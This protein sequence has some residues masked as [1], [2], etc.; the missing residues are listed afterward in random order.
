MNPVVVGTALTDKE[1]QGRGLDAL[2]RALRQIVDPAMAAAADGRPWVELYQAKESQRLGRRFEADLDDPRLLLRILRFERGVFTQIEAVQRAWIDEIIQAANRAA[3]ATQLSAAQADRA[4]ET[5]S[6]L[7]ESLGL[8]DV[9]DEITAL[10][11][12]GARAAE[13]EP[14]AVPS[15]P[16]APSAPSAP[17]IPAVAHRV[18]A[19]EPVP[20]GLRRLSARIGELDIEVYVREA[21]NFALVHNGVSPVAAVVV[22]NHGDA[23]HGGVAVTIDVDPPG[24][25]SAAPLG[26]TLRLPVEAIPPKTTIDAV[27]HL[28]AWRL[29]PG[30]FIGLEE[31]VT[32]SV[33]L[34]VHPDPESDRSF[35]DSDTIRLLPADEWWAVSI[36]EALAAFV[37]PN[38][39]AVA[40]LLTE[41]SAMLE[42][43]TGSPS[44]EGYQSGPDRVHAIAE[45]LYDALRARGITYVEPPA[46]FEG[47]GQRIRSHSEVLT[48]RRAT[49]L[50]L[51]CLAAAALEQAGLN[52]VLVLV[53]GHAFTGYLTEEME[54]PAVAVADPPAMITLADS[55]MFDAFETTAATAGGEPVPFDTARAMVRRWWREG[56]PRVR[57]LLDVRAAHRRVLP[58]PSVRWDGDVRVVEVA[59]APAALHLRRAPDQTRRATTGPSA[60]PR[61]E[62]WKRSLLDLTYNNPHLKLK[63]ASS[64]AVHVPA[65]GL[66]TLED[67]LEDE[68]QITLLP[69]DELA[70][71]HLAQ[72]ARTAADVAAESMLAILGAER[73]AHVAVP[74]SGYSARMRGLYRRARTSAEETGTSS[75]YLT[76]GTLEWR[77]GSTREGRAPL[78]LLPVRLVG[79]RGSAPFQL[80]RDDTRSLEPNL[81][82][83]EKLRTTWGIDIPALVDPLTDDAGIDVARNLQEVRTGLIRAKR[84]EFHVEETA[85]LAVLQFS[86]IDMWR[87]VRDHWEH[88]LERPVVRHLVETPGVPFDDGVEP[89]GTPVDAE[90]TTHLPIPADGSQIE[91]VRW[92]AA[93][94]TFILEGPPGTGKS[95]TITNL[96]AHCLAEGKSVLFVAEK[97]AALDVVR[98]RLDAVGLGLLSLDLH[99]KSQT[100]NAVREQISAALEFGGASSSTWE[101]LRARYQSL[102]TSLARY[103]GLL[104]QPG[105]ADMSAWDARQVLLDLEGEAGTHAGAR[106]DVPRT[107]V[108]GGVDLAHV[109]EAAGRLAEALGTLGAAPDSSPWS[110]AGAVDPESLDTA[111]LAAA[112]EELT[113]AEAALPEAIRDVTGRALTPAE[114]EDLA[115]WFDGAVHGGART[116]ADAARLVDQAW[117]SRADHVRR[118][119]ADFRQSDAGRLGPFGPSALAM[120][121]DALLQRSVEADSKFFGKKKRRLG[122]LADMAAVTSPGAQP[123][124]ARL[125]AHLTDLVALRAR[126][127]DLAAF[128]DQLPGIELPFGWNPLDQAHAQVWDRDVWAL[129]HAARLRAT[130]TAGRAPQEGA[131]AALDAM[132][133]HVLAT[134]NVP[135]GA[136][137]RRVGTAWATLTTMLASTDAD[138][139]R[140][141]AGRTRGEACARATGPWRG[142][143]AGSFLT[144]RRTAHVHGALAR[145]GSLGLDTMDDAVRSGALRSTDL[146]TQVR[147]GVARAIL[148]E[149]LAGT[150]LDAF[151]EEERDRLVARFIATGD[152][153]RKRMVSELGA[154]VVAARTFDPKARAGAVAELW[155]QLGKRRGGLSVRQ[156]LHR[157]G[158]L[159]TQITPC[160][161]MSPASVARFLPADAAGFDVVVFDEASQI[162][163]PDAVGAM[164]RARSA[165]IVGDSKQMPPSSAF[166]TSGAADEDGDVGDDAL[167]V[168]V[169]LESILSEGVESQLPRLLLSWHYR[170][171]D[172][173][174]I[175]FSNHQYYEGRLSTLPAPPD[176]RGGPPALEWR[177]VD[178]TW[179]GGARGANRVNRAEAQAIV[180][181]IRQLLAR[182][183][184]RSIGVITFNSQQRD[185][186]LNLLEDLRP[187]DAALDAALAQEDEPLFV[188]NL[189]NVQGDE[190]DLIL[191][192]LAFAKDSRGRMRLN[193]GPLT[194]S[195]GERRLNV[196]IT[197]AKER[198]VVFGSFDPHELDLSRS[199]SRGLADLKGYLLAAREGVERSSL[200]RSEAPDLHLDDVEFHL[201]RAGLEVRRRV[202][203]SDFT[204]DLAVRRPGAVPWVAVLLDGPAWAER[205]SV[206]DR[207]GLPA[208][209]LTGRM[210]W[211]RVERV[212]LPTWLRDRDSV[213]RQIVGAA[214]A[215]AVGPAVPDRVPEPEAGTVVPPVMPE[216]APDAAAPPTAH[217]TAQRVPAPSGEDQPV[218]VLAVRAAAE[219]ATPT[220]APPGPARVP[221]VGAS[222][223][224]RHAAGVLD[225]PSPRNRALVAEEIRDVIAA[226]GPVLADRLARIVANR[227]GLRQ[228]REARKDQILRLAPSDQRRTARNGD[229]VYW[230][231]GADREATD[232]FRVGN[233]G[234]G[235][236]ISEVAY[237]ELRN[238]MVFVVRGAHGMEREDALRETAREFG[239]LR[240][241]AKVRERLVGVLDGALA[242]GHLI[243]RGGYVEAR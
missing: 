148:E 184:S 182:D 37:R 110:L 40:T 97:Q 47:T 240:L 109:H 66:G 142:D 216:P 73:I 214:A 138:V 6:L 221:F 185:L 61:V 51:A 224:P 209:V 36:P 219:T 212:W 112:I 76:L 60:P 62:A 106:V 125:T 98:K 63:E 43:R 88:F 83:V 75:L 128:V 7:A 191:F 139:A 86:T 82:L 192:S 34:T 90:A 50:D 202:G 2:G 243:E 238:A 218:P 58:L 15:A 167:P 26:P 205:R 136:P 143:A 28:L 165:I 183:R 215:A 96:I 236:D 241:G 225:D 114:F 144:L 223:A 95:Q 44:L 156:L 150:G 157:Y 46:S 4:L 222:V 171:K 84:T 27:P 53:E 55:G 226:E 131:G 42:Q 92:A 227:V 162:R 200:K 168:P 25:P 5:I 190:R 160:F 130:M 113:R 179:E 29:S 127:R 93:G 232:A 210:G 71:I 147:Q 158:T 102:V 81:C 118:T 79:G 129:S 74:R 220:A 242:E 174:L 80:E 181:E 213:V 10:L 155:Q 133:A 67:L 119:V 24:G 159:I 107:V 35:R 208:T 3:H 211:S 108:S 154:R 123:D 231:L 64:I 120:D 207:E 203:L 193:W 101:S 65:D 151:D 99:G 12:P 91:A 197:R 72:G 206:G 45:A 87:D 149:R 18:P 140:W 137:V 152:D 11:A 233:T 77:E 69:S 234:A 1:R 230:P 111:A 134:G 117:L 21:L 172:E 177:R 186:I 41:A 52:P 145:L 198:V 100:P 33:H 173:S 239:T 94:K 235:R 126:T 166:S 121:L 30:P 56:L 48:D 204:V 13:P 68:Q 188:K 31:S 217:A 78:F 161:L 19:V 189:E 170:S 187:Q 132:T 199:A 124:P 17:A 9:V 116:T 70:Q 85:R 16:E 176:G 14:A 39:P 38:D 115:V 122:I 105:P 180:E 135:D 22:T 146:E 89:P 153:V 49:C 196:A 104:H 178:G 201:V 175:A 23:P 59:A 169:D 32:T 228:V 229:V 237:E 57:Y 141:L 20:A 194:R 195:G 8:Q 164:G 103:P 163:V 54:L